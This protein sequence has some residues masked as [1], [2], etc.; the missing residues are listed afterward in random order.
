MLVDSL[1]I[2][3]L[4]GKLRGG[5]FTNLIHVKIISPWLVLAAF[6]MQY[7]AMFI[8]PQLV[9]QAIFIS[10]V[11]LMLFC[12]LN[13]QNYGFYFMFAGIL[14]NVIV[15]F[16]NEGRMPVEGKAAQSLSPQ[17]YPALEAG[18]Y[19]KH[20]L[21]S[22]QTKLNFLGDIFYLKSPYPHPTIVSLGDIIFSIGVILFI[23][24]MMRNRN[25]ISQDGRGVHVK[26]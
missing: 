24:K 17:D 6:S 12:F 1:V 2:G 20:V 21:M 4:V 16:A 25:S 26:V 8:F 5:R 15:M 23:Y 3:F 7:V 10:Y 11:C 19:G 18:V 22:D 14:L 13:R 9:Q